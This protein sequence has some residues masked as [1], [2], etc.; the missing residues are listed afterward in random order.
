MFLDIT[1]HIRFEGAEGNGRNAQ[2]TFSLLEAFV[3]PAQGPSVDVPPSA[4]VSGSLVGV[5]RRVDKVTFRFGALQTE[6]FPCHRLERRA[7]CQE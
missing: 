1:T 6:W 7:A 3:G 2:V 5:K 4:A